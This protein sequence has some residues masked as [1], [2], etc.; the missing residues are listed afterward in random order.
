MRSVGRTK[1]WFITL[2]MAL[3]F[4][5]LWGSVVSSAGTFVGAKTV[6]PPIEM[7][8]FG[9]FDSSFTYLDYGSNSILDNGNQ[10]VDVEAITTAKQSVNYVGAT[11]QLQ[12]WT[13]TEW[14]SVGSTHTLSNTNKSYFSNG[15]R[16][17]VV[18]GYYY[19]VH[20]IH[21]T[22]HGGVYE[23]GSITSGHIL[24]Q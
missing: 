22:T 20:T 19:R 8:P 5:M 9:F 7:R 3:F 2:W 10:T 24:A 18:S 14:I 12:R 6:P 1:R 11:F 16:L 13:G 17:G 23:S 4:V 21:W 15:V